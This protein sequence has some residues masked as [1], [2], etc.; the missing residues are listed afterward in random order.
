[1][2]IASAADHGHMEI[3]ELLCSAALTRSPPDERGFRA[4]NLSGCLIT[5]AS[6]RALSK[7]LK[8]DWS[9]AA[10]D[11]SGNQIGDAGALALAEALAVNPNHTVVNLTGNMIGNDGAQVLAEA[12]RMNGHIYRVLRLGD[13]DF[14]EEGTQSLSRA[15]AS[16]V[17][18]IEGVPGLDEEALA[19]NISLAA[20][21]E[22][23][24]KPRIRSLTS[25]LADPTDHDQADVVKDLL[26]RSSR[27]M[28]AILSAN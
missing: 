14:G 21:R 8:A 1:V 2:P 9:V 15:L 26:R 13:N 22:T 24:V 18:V 10:L 6:A 27:A 3:C 16:T 7:V 28:A 11:L 17:C 4:V 25:L 5:D 20:T 12:L 23:H 19:F